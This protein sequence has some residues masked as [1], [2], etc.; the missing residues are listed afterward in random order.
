MVEWLRR[1]MSKR[2]IN[3][4]L[5]ELLNGQ[6]IAAAALECF[7][8][9]AV[10]AAL[11][12]LNDSRAKGSEGNQDP[13]PLR[14][15]CRV[16]K[17][18]APAAAVEIVAPQL[19]RLR[20]DARKAVVD[21]LVSI[22][23]PQAWQAITAAVLDPD[24][25]QSADARYALWGAVRHRPGDKP[26]GGDVEQLV[27][28]LTAMAGQTRAFE[29]YKLAQT[30]LSL[31]RPAAIEALT[32][33]DFFQREHE[34]VRH[35]LDALHQA[36]AKPPDGATAI[37]REWCRRAW[38]TPQDDALGRLAQMALPLVARAA[39]EEAP[40]LIEKFRHRAGCGSWGAAEA[41]AVLHGVEDAYDHVAR[42]VFERDAEGQVHD[43]FDKLTHPQQVYWVCFEVDAQVCNGGF[44]QFFFNP[45]GK[46]SRLAPQAL[47]EVGA[48]NRS[49]LMLKALEI[50]GPQ[51]VE[52]AEQVY[53]NIMEPEVRSRLSELDTQYYDKMQAEPVLELLKYYAAR[54]A[55]HF[56]SER[57]GS[58]S[59]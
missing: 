3:K 39:P 1:Q 10:P 42:R 21:L 28:S 51:Q 18:Y 44:E 24:T 32:R 38:E 12:G 46:Y 17:P 23:T 26:S 25:T 43:R 11:D 4:W 8:E 30:L 9:E 58:P 13:E 7:G 16:L 35:V 2:R 5:E 47:A 31:D 52:A 37:L 41:T 53:L 54:H 40:A 50:L 33:A 27:R 15:L 6:S 48:A 57:E 45:S 14:G 36:K 34:D 20:G 55:G 56:R 19:P 59:S 22:D 49:S 29:L